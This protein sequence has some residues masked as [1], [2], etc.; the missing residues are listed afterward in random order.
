MRSPGEEKS[1]ALHEEQRHY[2]SIWGAFALSFGFAVGWGAFVMP[3]TT[4]LPGAGPLGTVFGVLLGALAMT[5]F[6]VN[7]HRL[8]LRYPG[9]GGAYSFAQ[10]VFGEDHGFLV[11]WFLWFTYIAILW[12]NATSIILVI[13]FTLGNAL[14]FGFHYSVAGFDV[15]MGEVLLSIFTIVA[16]GAVCIASKRLT[17]VVQIILAILMAVGVFAF[18]AFALARH[19]GGLASMGPAF[20]DDVHP[21][22]QISRILALM[23]W[24]FVGFESITHSTGEF[25][26]PVKKTWII[27]ALAIILST[28][29]YA[30]LALLPVLT[31]PSEESTWLELVRKMA[32]K[33]GIGG[34]PVFAAAKQ[35]FGWSGIALMSTLMIAGQITGIIA[36]LVALSRLMHAMSKSGVLPKWYGALNASGT[37][38]NAIYFVAGISCIIPFFGRT[39]IGWPVDVSSIGAA[40]AYGYTSEAA[41]SI[42]RD[43][44]GVGFLGKPL[45]IFGMVLSMFFCLLLLIP[46]YISGSVLAAPSYLFLALWCI[47]GFL[48]YRKI[49]KDDHNRRF[50]RS[51]VV[52]NTL[53]IA[54][55]FASLM[56]VRQTSFENARSIINDYAMMLPLD[57]SRTE[58]VVGEKV[59]SLNASMLCNA[60]V[61]LVLIL[62]AIL[63]LSS[64]LSIMR[65][66]ELKLV[67]E[68]AR[69]EDINNA[70]T[71]FFSTVSHDIRTPLN[72]IIG[73][74]QMLK[75]GFDTKEEQDQAIDSIIM[76]GKTLLKLVNDV[77]DLS[78]LESGKMTIEPEPTDCRHLLEEI[79]ES[80]RVST[81]KAQV[82]FRFKCG[83]MPHLMLDA[84]RIRQIAFNLMGN[85][86]KFTTKGFIEVRASF[87]VNSGKG[88]RGLFTLDVE[89]S[90]CGISKAD[91]KHIFTP[92]VQVG[93]KNSRHSGTGLG[94][95][96]TSELVKAMGGKTKVF[97]TMGKGTTFRII[98]PNVK[99]VES[100]EVAH[101][102][103]HPNL[104]AASTKKLRRVLL[105]DDQKIN[106][107]VLKAMLA[108]MG[109][110]DFLLAFNGKEALEMLEDPASGQIDMVMTD[111]W[112]PEM[113]GE[114]LVQAIRKNPKFESLPVYAITADVEGLKNYQQF[115]FTDILLKPITQESLRGLLRN[116]E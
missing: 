74:S 38:R 36:S 73:F 70:K 9:S 25:H 94:L 116:I 104:H 87:K 3:G 16:C 29:M 111:M 15:Y 89:D 49:F 80:F 109:K 86:V 52:W 60:A 27:L 32:G 41:Y 34:V 85:A 40:I 12:A 96:I 43:G 106:L 20:A 103:A 88:D 18:F 69:M 79:T 63:I 31:L 33:P 97:S 23:P 13:R 108:K 77:L 19:E 110:F 2:L 11:A 71:F 7:Y 56:W 62:G 100:H 39:A 66:R 95:T 21:V 99:I 78:K 1:S 35:L 59:S 8:A 47:L 83:E 17:M 61:E 54:I 37:P 50:G 51:V 76:S 75:D 81:Q 58:T 68:N 90:G 113:D 45:A 72:S 46:N 84:E 4:F 14:Q 105:V 10:K 64:L 57:N 22:L 82:E 92:F 28:C 98:I 65:R 101:K 26:F 42:C 112:M 55:I 114:A 93:A 30:F 115:G 5:V 48:Y 6:A 107:M 53:V 44:K 67:A 24:A 91:L 102:D